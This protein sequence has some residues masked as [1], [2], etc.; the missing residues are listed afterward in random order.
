W[1][2]ANALGTG[3]VNHDGVI[4]GTD[5]AGVLGSWGACP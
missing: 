4:D 1:G 2:G 5:L 3:D